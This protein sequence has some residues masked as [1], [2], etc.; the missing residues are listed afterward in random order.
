MRFSEYVAIREYF[1]R[2]QGMPV[3]SER[4][5]LAIIEDPLNNKIVC[6]DRYEIAHNLLVKVED[7]IAKVI[8]DVRTQEVVHR[9]TNE[10]NCH[11]RR[12]ALPLYSVPP[13]F[14]HSL[15][16]KNSSGKRKYIPWPF[17]KSG[18]EISHSPFDWKNN[19][20]LVN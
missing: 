2:N 7:V 9:E 17:V 11:D 6:L 12:T 20:H 5:E 10:T 18:Y 4:V 13:S 14:R 16:Q 3:H 15:Q 19:D 1:C 8:V